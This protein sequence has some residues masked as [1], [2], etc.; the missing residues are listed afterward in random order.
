MSKVN[1]RIRLDT[2]LGYMFN[3]ITGGKFSKFIK[4][5]YDH[6]YPTYDR[7]DTDYLPQFVILSGVSFFVEEWN[8]MEGIDLP[9]AVIDST[10]VNAFVVLD[11]AI[12]DRQGNLLAF[13]YIVMT[14][15]LMSILT[16]D[17]GIA[18]LHHEMRHS[19][20]HWFLMIA[21]ARIFNK[22]IEKTDHLVLAV[23]LNNILYAPFSWAMEF[24]ADRIP[25]E[26]RPH[27][28]NAL[29]KMAE[30]DGYTVRGLVG[31]CSTHPPISIRARLLKK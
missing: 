21:H 1:W 16:E 12:E 18:V 15:A 31:A 4:E 2:W 11:A 30:S 13:E 10:T 29:I 6:K 14:T 27:L 7:F 8:R 26:F 28:A 5:W 9:V 22:V 19:K 23:R 3:M 25:K 20:R 17:E 24:D